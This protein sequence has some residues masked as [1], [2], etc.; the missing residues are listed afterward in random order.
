MK[1][2]NL[3]CGN[4]YSTSPEWTNIDI[5]SSG[6]NVMA[7]DLKKGVPFPD[8][9]FDLIYHSHVFE[10]IPKSQADSFI[11]ECIRVLRP[12]GILRIVIPDL[13][14]IVRNYI[15]LLDSGM[16]NL[17]SDKIAADYD[18]IMLEMYDQ[19]VRNKSGGE[20]MKF[21]AD[22]K[23]SNQEF[24][25]ERCGSEIKKIITGLNNNNKY[26]LINNQPKP[27]FLN[28][29]LNYLGNKEL[30]RRIL[31]RILFKKEHGL[32]YKDGSPFQV[33][34]FREEGEVHQW[35]YDRYSI[36]RIFTKNLLRNIKQQKAGESYLEN[37]STY[38]LDTQEDKTVYK[39]DSIY[40]EAIK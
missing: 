19:V 7:Y 25:I 20:M 5:V 15:R 36:N 6:E 24:V 38:N 27:A 13:E 18:W 17:E 30:R 22:E 37:W 28:K 21:I 31:L 10:H 16:N 35:M 34:K 14:Q 11:K 9:S 33:G 23:F 40:M 2:L 32:L 3:G 29:V 1:Y 26:P 12:N 4:R 39:P 8:E